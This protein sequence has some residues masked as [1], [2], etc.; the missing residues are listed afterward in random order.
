MKKA[1]RGIGCVLSIAV[2]VE[3][4]GVAHQTTRGR[5][6]PIDKAT[7]TFFIEEGDQ[8]SGYRP[9][10]RDLAAWAF[11]AWERSSA[12]GLHLEPSREP[13]A[14][15]RLYWASPNGTTYGEMRAFLINGR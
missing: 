10:D 5:V 2:L 15:V 8:A 6:L 13:N 1:I 7:Y 3:R 9:S 14:L 4:A 12:G 11:A